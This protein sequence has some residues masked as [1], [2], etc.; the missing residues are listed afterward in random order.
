MNY[1]IGKM[2]T[3]FYFNDTSTVDLKNNNN[4]YSGRIKNIQHNNKILH[5]YLSKIQL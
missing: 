1:C 2:G 5:C 4:K 3:L